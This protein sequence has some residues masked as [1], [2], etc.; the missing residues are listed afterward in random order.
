MC[1]YRPTKAGRND[2]DHR[3]SEHLSA[4]CRQL[5][6][7]L[8]GDVARTLIGI[9]GPCNRRRPA[10]PPSVRVR[11][12]Q[13]QESNRAMNAFCLSV[14]HDLRTPLFALSR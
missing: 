11:T 9:G 7:V 13:L 1:L 6:P 2:V 4:H 3:P 14:T 5:H 8:P 10:T 12:E